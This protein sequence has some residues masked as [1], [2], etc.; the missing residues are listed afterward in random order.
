MGGDEVG[1][2]DRIVFDLCIAAS[3]LFLVSIRCR[4]LSLRSSEP[5]AVQKPA[6][7]TNH[8]NNQRTVKTEGQG[9]TGVGWT[10]GKEQERKQ[11]GYKNNNNEAQHQSAEL[12]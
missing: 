3:L 7:V 6:K 9:G 2:L 5:A 12:N 1:V 11:M 10:Q 8:K 4:V